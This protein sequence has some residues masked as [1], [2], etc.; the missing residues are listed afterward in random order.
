MKESTN[1]KYKDLNEK[2]EDLEEKLAKMDQC[3]VNSSEDIDKNIEH[4]EHM[5][6]GLHKQLKLN[7]E[8]LGDIMD[9][10]SDAEK[11]K[12]VKGPAVSR[13]RFTKQQLRIHLARL[14]KKHPEKTCF[15]RG[16]ELYLNGRV[17]E[18]SEE[19]KKLVR[20]LATK[21]GEKK[22]GSLM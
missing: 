13:W 9:N 18:Y 14:K 4:L 6:K 21:T 17:F 11:D 22:D 8:L 2:T 20:Q 19:K 1:K 3:K 16:N 7:E 10:I 5:L 15:I 12:Y